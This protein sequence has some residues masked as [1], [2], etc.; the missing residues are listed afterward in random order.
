[1]LNINR[2]AYIGFT[3]HEVNHCFSIYHKE[4]KKNG[5]ISVYMQKNGW[6][7]NT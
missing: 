4:T 5:F 2:V 6:K 3:D 7:L 1:M